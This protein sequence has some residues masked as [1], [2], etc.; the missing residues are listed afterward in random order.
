MISTVFERVLLIVAGVGLHN[1]QL[2][3]SHD[4][5]SG[6]FELAHLVTETSVIPRNGAFIQ[7]HADE[8]VVKANQ[9]ASSRRIVPRSKPVPPLSSSD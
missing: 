3:Q 8:P 4:P 2:F 6:G 5:G 7:K 1:R 9:E